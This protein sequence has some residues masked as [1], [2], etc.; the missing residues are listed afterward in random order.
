MHKWFVKQWYNPSSFWVYLLF[1]L[2]LIYNFIAKIRRFMYRCGLKKKVNF[3]IPVIVVGNITVGGVG[4][5]PLVAYLADLLLKHGYEPGIVSRGYKGKTTEWPVAV[6]ADSDPALVGDE[7]VML[8]QQTGCP[9]AI[10]PD[11]PQAVEFLLKNFNC[12]IILSDDG[13]QH[14]ALDR[15]IE[16]AVIDGQ[17]RL[18]NGHYFPMGPLRESKLRLDHCDFIVV[19]GGKLENDSEY[20][21]DLLPSE[22]VSVGFPSKTLALDAAEINKVHAVTGIGNP[23]RFFDLLS[24]L[25]LEFE[26]HAFPDHHQFSKKD[27]SFDDDAYVIMTEKDAVKCREIATDKHFYLPVT[28]KLSDSFNPTFLEKIKNCKSRT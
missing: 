28:V 21:M 18:G 9:M 1:P 5:S 7:A 16:I 8:V 19:N 22:L 17:R 4:K 13:L 10:S 11:R 25:G 2:S 27:I 12:D 6:N 23:Q 14:Y 26:A 20:K 3:S 15:D 24:A